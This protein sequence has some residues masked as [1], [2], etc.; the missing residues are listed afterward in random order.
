MSDPRHT[1]L[2]TTQQEDENAPP[3]ET[4]GFLPIE[5]NWFDRLFISVVLWIA[6]S[7]FWFRFLEPAGL[8]I[9]I[10]NAIAVVMAFII[11]RKG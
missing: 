8:S 3:E 1:P 2:A 4:A 5:T 6:L 11:I 9:W 10:A 7:L